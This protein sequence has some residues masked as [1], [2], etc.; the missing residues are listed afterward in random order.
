LQPAAAP[1]FSSNGNSNFN[2]GS[3]LLLVWRVGVGWQD[4]P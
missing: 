3:G 1:L 2:S 4:T